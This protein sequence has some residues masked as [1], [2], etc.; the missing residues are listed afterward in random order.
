LAVS[1]EPW[2]F[3]NGLTAPLSVRQPSSK[4]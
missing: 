3:L 1:D 4:V 2:P